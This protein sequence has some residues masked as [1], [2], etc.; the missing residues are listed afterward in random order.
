MLQ[1]FI[2]AQP[3]F[4]CRQSATQTEEY[5]LDNAALQAAV[6]IAHF[7]KDLLFIRRRGRC[8]FDY[9]AGLSS[10][11][12]W[13]LNFFS[14]RPVFLRESEAREQPKENPTDRD[15]IRDDS[16]VDL[17]QVLGL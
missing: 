13:L 9:L 6:S 12:V 11:D 4:N 10:R 15:G 2:A 17:P 16:E 14:Q 7:G 1:A 3:T 5:A 8:R